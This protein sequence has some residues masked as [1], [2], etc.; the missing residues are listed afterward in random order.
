V[1]CILYFFSRTKK[2][3]RKKRILTNEVIILH[4]PFLFLVNLSY[5]T[6]PKRKEKITLAPKLTGIFK[7]AHDAMPHLINTYIL[8]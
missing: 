3:R 1:F 4:F 5:S 2:R 6:Y 7:V 8:K